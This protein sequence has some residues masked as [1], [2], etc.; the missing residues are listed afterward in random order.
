VSE[1]EHW[2]FDQSPDTWAMTTREIVDRR[3]AILAVH[4]DD[5]DGGWQFL[6]PG[7]ASSEQACLISMQ[8]AVD[9][10]PSL[11]EVADLAPGWRATRSKPTDPWE[12]HAPKRV[13]PDD[14]WG[15][16]PGVTPK[17]FVGVFVQ[18]LGRLVRRLKRMLFD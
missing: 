15:L 13:L 14:P 10:D 9:L 2:P 1:P 11:L 16:D 4:H 6:G 12:R 8:Q 7:G 17:G 3:E 18:V 5:D